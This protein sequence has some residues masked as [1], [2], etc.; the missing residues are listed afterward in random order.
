M[1]RVTIQ[2]YGELSRGVFAILMDKPD[3]LPAQQVLQEVEASVPPTSFEQEAYEKPPGVR[4][5][6]KHVRF[7]SISPVKAGWL[8]KDEGQWSRVKGATEQAP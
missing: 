3:G 8:V 1:A 4:R 5:Y 6:P 7:A 2:R